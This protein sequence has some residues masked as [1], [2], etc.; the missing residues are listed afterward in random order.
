MGFIL[1]CDAAMKNK[2]YLSLIVLLILP[3]TPAIAGMA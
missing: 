3:A 2:L 1:V